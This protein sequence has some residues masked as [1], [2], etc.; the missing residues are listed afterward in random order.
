MFP[1]RL[2]DKKRIRTITKSKVKP[3][4]P[5][6][7]VNKNGGW[8]KSASTD[9]GPDDAEFQLL[10]RVSFLEWISICMYVFSWKVKHRSISLKPQN[11]STTFKKI[12]LIS[13][14]LV[15]KSF[16]ILLGKQFG[17][18]A[19]TLFIWDNLDCFLNKNDLHFVLE[20]FKNR[21]KNW[22]EIEPLESTN[23]N[24]HWFVISNS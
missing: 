3:R 11:P 17:Y 24:S 10:L 15:R 21:L 23:G 16:I 19:L 9:N 12:Y 18:L 4:Q 7:K 1:N 5:E 14:T 8:L 13:T 22:I 20:E 2:K 6:A